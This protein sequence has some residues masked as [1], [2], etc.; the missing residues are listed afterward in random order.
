MCLDPPPPCL[1]A[2]FERYDLDMSG[3]CNSSAELSQMVTN[4]CT[5]L[6]STYP[7][8]DFDQTVV[9]ACIA[10]RAVSPTNA[11]DLQGF[12]DFFCATYKLEPS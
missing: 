1:E 2:V 10:E 5:K 7:E 8:W 4:L 12:R 11:M 6:W 3:T 9:D